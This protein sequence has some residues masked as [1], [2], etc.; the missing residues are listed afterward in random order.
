MLKRVHIHAKVNKVKFL[1]PKYLLSSYILF[2][3]PSKV[4]CI[5]KF[6]K[7]SSFSYGYSRL[8]TLNRKLWCYWRYPTEC[9]RAMLNCKYFNVSMH[10]VMLMHIFYSWKTLAKELEGFS[11][12]QPLLLILI[13]EKSSILSQLQYHVNHVVLDKSI[14]KLDN[15]GMVYTAMKIYFS[16]E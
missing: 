12:A 13:A 2:R 7:K 3:K 1:K 6:H 14:P 16:L 4:P 9:F 8:P 11:L 5:N 10:P 15:V